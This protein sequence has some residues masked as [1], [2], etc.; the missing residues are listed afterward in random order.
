M[1]KIEFIKTSLH[2]HFGGKSADFARGG[3]NTNPLFD[4]RLAETK[5]DNASVN[6][7]K[8]LALTN[9][10]VF[11]KSE[12][13]ALNKYIEDNNHNITLI[14]GA[15]LDIVDDKSGNKQYLHVVILISPSSNLDIFTNSIEQYITNNGEYAV[16]IEQLTELVYANKI[17]LIPHG[18]KQ[19]KR[20]ALRNI[21]SFD[22]ILSIRDFFP[23]LIEDKSAVKRAI[24]ESKIRA[25]LTSEEFEWLTNSGSI[26]SLDQGNDFSSIKEPTLDHIRP[27]S[28]GGKDVLQNLTIC[29]RITNQEKGDRFSTWNA[30]GKTFQAIRVKGNRAAYQIK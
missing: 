4:M 16:T 27:L 21:P 17:I 15:E 26:S 14:P 13:L 9:H 30:N 3:V 12:Y 2:N 5:I 19:G 24:F 23:I 6:K 28:K 10:N 20:S 1:E 7:Y 11:W 22:D 8:L 18:T 25:R 29:N